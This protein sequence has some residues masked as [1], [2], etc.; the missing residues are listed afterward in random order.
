MS[1]QLELMESRLNAMAKVLIMSKI[2][3]LCEVCEGSGEYKSPGYGA[4]PCYGCN[5]AGVVSND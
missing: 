3:K 5:G 2:A 1:G 4:E